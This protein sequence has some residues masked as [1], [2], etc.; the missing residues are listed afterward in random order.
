MTPEERSIREMT[1]EFADGEIRPRSAGWDEHRRLDEDVLGMLA[2]FGFLGMGIPEAFGGLGLDLSTC[3]A[4]TEEL[5]RADGSLALSVSLQNGPV[6]SLLLAHASEDLQHEL[7][8]GIA[9]GERLVALALGDLGAAG[10]EAAGD[11]TATPAG[12]GWRLDGRKHWVVDGN[13]AGAAMVFARPGAQ[14]G[15][16][17]AGVFLVD[18]SAPGYRV[19]RRRETLGLCAAEIVDVE[20]DG[21]AVSAHRV[22]GSPRLGDEYAAQA[23]PL[24]RLGGAA[25]ALGIAQAAFEHA[26]RYSREREQF[27][28]A[29]TA[30]GAIRHKLAGMAT[31]IAA[32]RALVRETA[33]ALEAPGAEGGVGL[34]SWTDRPGLTATPDMARW[35]A[36]HA[37]VSV[38]R[39]AVQI[40]GGYGYMRDYPVEKLMRDASG[41]GICEATGEVLRIIA[42]RGFQATVATG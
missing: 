26:A 28:R 38:A 4:A 24:S 21:L 7:L 8:P 33:V 39:E 16:G 13:R 37:A 17:G 2:E 36:S 32:A 11:A 12:D 27:G 19:V 15:T 35:A 40:F 30:F 22:I 18:T 34:A 9:S 5:A 14:G 31:R 29:L 1:R 41:T 25:V 6:A 42:A 20:L 3:L 10:A 23:L